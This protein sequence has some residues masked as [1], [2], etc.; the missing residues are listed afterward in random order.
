[1]CVCMYENEV[2]ARY[3]FIYA[4]TKNEVTSTHASCINLIV[5]ESTVLARHLLIYP[6]MQTKYW[7]VVYSSM[8]A[9]K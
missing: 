5:L 3:V 2:L 1:M 6:C 4:C 7:H 9:Q 8:H